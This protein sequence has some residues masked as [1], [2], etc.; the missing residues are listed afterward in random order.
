MRSSNILLFGVLKE[1]ILFS[2]FLKGHIGSAGLIE[3]HPEMGM[4]ISESLEYLTGKITGIAISLSG[5]DDA[6]Y[7]EKSV[8]EATAYGSLHELRQSVLAGKTPC[9]AK[10]ENF[11][12]ISITTFMPLMAAYVLQAV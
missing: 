9:I 5:E 8:K 6:Y 2:G 3:R 4:T 7:T 11:A 12:L 1:E 10:S